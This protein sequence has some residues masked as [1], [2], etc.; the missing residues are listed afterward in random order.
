[1]ILNSLDGI[2]SCPTLCITNSNA[3]EKAHA[4]SIGNTIG[5]HFAP[6]L[7]CPMCSAHRTNER[8]RFLADSRF[9]KANFMWTQN[10]LTVKL[11]NWL[12]IALSYRSC[13]QNCITLFRAIGSRRLHLAH[14]NPSRV[15][16]RP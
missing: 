7:T 11:K 9:S 13:A 3:C 12:D 10:K 5:I 15:K 16:P 8:W 6:F 1:M 14:L 2:I 4:I